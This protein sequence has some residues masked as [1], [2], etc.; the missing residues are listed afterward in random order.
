MTP[1]KE[2]MDVLMAADKIEY[3]TG[4]PIDYICKLFEHGAVIRLHDPND[5]VLK[6]RIRD[7]R[8]ELMKRLIEIGEQNNNCPYRH[9]IGFDICGINEM[10][11]LK[12][13]GKCYKEM[14]ENEKL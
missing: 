4:Y 1:C 3:L 14:R 6:L 8:V 12:P 13:M 10:T 5:S 7:S 9:G 11:C 2:V